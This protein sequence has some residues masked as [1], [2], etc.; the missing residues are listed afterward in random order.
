LPLDHGGYTRG[1]KN[2]PA[3]LAESFLERDYDTIAIAG[4]GYLR[5]IYGFDRG[6]QTFLPVF[7]AKK[8]LN[9]QGVYLSSGSD[10]VDANYLSEEVVVEAYESFIGDSLESFITYCRQRQLESENSQKYPYQLSPAVHDFDFER[11][12]TLTE[13]ALESYRADSDR[14]TRRLLHEYPDIG[15]LDGL[16]VPE[17]HYS[18]AAIT[19]RQRLKLYHEL[20]RTYFSP[21]SAVGPSPSNI[22]RRQREMRWWIRDRFYGRWTS[23][24]YMMEIL[25]DW[26][27]ERQRPF[28]AWVHTFDM[29][30]NNLFTWEV[31]DTEYHDQEVSVLVEF[32]EN[33][34]RHGSPYEDAIDYVLTA[35]YTDLVIQRFVEQLDELLSEPPLLVITADHGTSVQRNRSGDHVGQFY[36]EQL[37]IP[38]A[39]VH[40]SIDAGS[41]DG[42]CSGIDIPAT[43]LDLLGFEIPLGFDGRSV[44]DLPESGRDHVIA[45]DLGR[46]ICNPNLKPANI[47]V[48][49][50]DR[51]INCTASVGEQHNLTTETSYDLVADPDEK[52]VIEHGFFV[53]RFRAYY[54]NCK[55]TD[56]RHQFDP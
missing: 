11:V 1:I 5:R 10:F 32:L 33:V 31:D 34:R 41:F 2:R 54:R 53:P 56:M 46:G 24:G 4:G 13:Q 40:P 3:V 17:A 19:N 36:N 6:F 21:V 50:T 12:I 9:F 18:E 29:H 7:P 26:V 27:R 44:F 43:L 47:S 45:E 15:F 16:S 22:R 37:H 48:Q 55:T 49:T 14:F 35:R 30:R 20:L 52:K 23:G 8:W 39:F 51:K 25:H 28:F 38:V 42:L